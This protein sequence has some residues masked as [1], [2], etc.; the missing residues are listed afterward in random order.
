MKGLKKRRI[1]A[2]NER[3]FKRSTFL[4]I[5]LPTRKAMAM[6]VALKTEGLPSTKK[7]KKV[8]RRIKRQQIARLGIL[9]SLKKE[10]RRK[11]MMAIWAPD[12]AKRW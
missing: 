8:K 4:Q 2:L 5:N 9:R 12:M 3:V 11:E 7:A 10:K 6:T 1:K